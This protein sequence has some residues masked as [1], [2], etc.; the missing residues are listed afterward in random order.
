MKPVGRAILLQS[1]DSGWLPLPVEVVWLT[2]AADWSFVSSWRAA[3]RRGDSPS[4]RDSLEYAALAGKRWRY[5]AG[6]DVAPDSPA[7]LRRSI[8]QQPF[9]EFGIALAMREKATGILGFAFARRTWA[10][11]LTLEFLAVSPQSNPGIKGTGAALMQALA[12]IGLTIRCEELWG[13]CTE[14]LAGILPNAQRTNPPVE[15]R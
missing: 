5:L 11:S 6:Q 14:N 10:N 4:L 15:S 2:E 9:G 8:R 7:A 3:A 13:E 1:H 12:T